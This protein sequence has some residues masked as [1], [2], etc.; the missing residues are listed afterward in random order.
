MLYPTL[1]SLSTTSA[2][3]ND[4]EYQDGILSIKRGQNLSYIYTILKTNYLK[5]NTKIK[6]CIETAFKVHR[7]VSIN[8]CN[9]TKELKF[10]NLAG[11]FS[12]VFSVSFRE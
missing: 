9:K 10:N 2:L 1:S 8:L 11:Q 12:T 4:K 6:R 5:K 3:L 7:E